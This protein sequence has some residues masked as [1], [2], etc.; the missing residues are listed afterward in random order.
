METITD[1]R[2]HRWKKLNVKSCT[3]T[4]LNLMQ[5]IRH[6][7]DLNSGHASSKLLVFKTFSACRTVLSDRERTSHEIC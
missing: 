6:T 1:C 3:C 4:L 7:Q 5:I 2:G